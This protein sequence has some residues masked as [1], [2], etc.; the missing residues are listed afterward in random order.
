MSKQLI[1]QPVDGLFTCV[2]GTPLVFFKFLLAEALER[3][4]WA[5][6]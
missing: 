4:Q 6:A 1:N 3:E 5:A 2:V